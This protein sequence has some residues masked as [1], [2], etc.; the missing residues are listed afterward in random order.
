MKNSALQG[1][2]N[3]KYEQGVTADNYIHTALNQGSSRQKWKVECD[4]P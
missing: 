3:K 4:R 1:Y 2:K